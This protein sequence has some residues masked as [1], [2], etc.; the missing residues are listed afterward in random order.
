MPSPY[1]NY[2]PRVPTRPGQP[3]RPQYAP[4]DQTGALEMFKAVNPQFFNRPQVTSSFGGRPVSMMAPPMQ[5]GSTMNGMRVM[6]G[7][8]GPAGGPQPS[9]G[10]SRSPWASVLPQTQGMPQLPDGQLQQ[11]P[12][13]NPIAEQAQK[14][15]AAANKANDD[16][17]HLLL[18]NEG[19][20][21]QELLTALNGWNPLID[22]SQKDAS[23]VRQRM[24][25]GWDAILNLAGQ[26]GI[27]SDLERERRRSK[28][29][30]GAN[31][32]S[33][34]NRGL[35]N[36]T[37]ADSTRRGIVDDSALR[38]QGIYDAQRQR[39]LG[40]RQ[41]MMSQTIPTEMRLNEG[42]QQLGIG[43]LQQLIPALMQS[44][45]NRQGIIERRSDQGP[46]TALIAQLLSQQ[47][48]TQNSNQQ[49]ANA[50]QA[51]QGNAN[52]QYQGLLNS[53]LGQMPG[54][55]GG[56]GGIGGAHNGGSA[57]G[58]GGLRRPP[59]G[60]G[61]QHTGATDVN[62]GG[63]NS[64]PG[65]TGGGDPARSQPNGWQ[66]YQPPWAQGPAAPGRMPGGT[67]YP[68]G[69]YGTDSGFTDAEDFNLD[70][71]GLSDLYAPPSAQ[72]AQT[73]LQSAQQ[74]Y[75]RMLS[76]YLGYNAQGAYDWANLWGP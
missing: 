54:F 11:A 73:D 53:I 61:E 58:F 63:Y 22:Q 19:A 14:D 12:A 9:A 71:L 7:A 1:S 51:A 3:Q 26:N 60:S 25:S 47:G 5:A 17:Y 55:G 16:R 68:G 42:T 13:G 20:D 41:N 33:L 67:P 44:N 56:G 66:Q 21:K 2:V 28:N 48:A 38:E 40:V 59:R 15:L 75:Q 72:S 10:P 29:E 52:G 70:D 74:D 35:T 34:V 8:A 36:T 76:A 65:G 32:Q 50:L 46:Q 43:Q 37:I 23:G 31:S 45:Q 18:Q 30:Q 24:N 6:Q 39:E 4:P 49:I 27:Q 57:P 64:A 69:Q 62:G